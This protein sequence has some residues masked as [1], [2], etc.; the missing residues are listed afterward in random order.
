MDDTVITALLTGVGTVIGSGFASWR[1]S[2]S[3]GSQTT[4][5]VTSATTPA[6]EV[7]AAKVDGV[8]RAQDALS[9]DMEAHRTE[10]RQTGVAVLADEITGERIDRPVLKEQRLGNSGE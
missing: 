8:A 2:K 9:E 1:A 6:L 3:A 10:A 5:Q 7:L 4:K